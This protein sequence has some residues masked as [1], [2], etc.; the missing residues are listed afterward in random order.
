M[1]LDN[2]LLPNLVTLYQRGLLVP[3]IGSGMS[4]P[5][6]TSWNI[7]LATL[8]HQAGMD[9][10]ARK[11][12][13]A[14]ATLES[15]ALYR[16]A[17]TVVH[18]MH[19]LPH[20]EKARRYREG[21]H[22]HP[23]GSQPIP[24]QMKALT[25]GLYWP[26]VLTTNYDDLYWAACKERRNT[27]SLD[28]LSSYDKQLPL[29]LGR[30]LEDC[31]TVLRSLDRISPP[32][33]WAL[34]GFLGGQRTTP[35]EIVSD[36]AHLQEL[37]SQV[38][39]GHQQ[40]Q[41]AINGDSH[42]RRAFAEV[43]RRRSLLFLGSGILEDYLLNLFSEIIY[44]HGPSAFPHIAILPKHE[45]DSGR[46]D[47]RFL[48][49]R[50]GI[51]PLFWENYGDI[52]GLLS[53]LKDATLPQW[54]RAGLSTNTALLR[55]R[56]YVLPPKNLRVLLSFRSKLTPPRSGTCVAFSAGRGRIG[57]N[58]GRFGRKYLE[59]QGKTDH[60][61][62]WNLAS[63][64]PNKDLYQCEA[65]SVF[66]V[67]ARHPRGRGI[68]RD[69]ALIPD[70]VCGALQELEGKG[71]RKVYLGVIAAGA[72]S[73]KLWHPIH[74]FAQNLRGIWKFAACSTG[75][76]HEIEM[77][78]ID[79]RIWALIAADKL[80]I[81]EMLTASSFPFTVELHRADRHV[82][83]YNLL[84]RDGSTVGEVLAQCELE[85]SHWQVKLRPHP[86]DQP[87]APVPTDQIVTATM[88][89]IVFPS[90]IGHVIP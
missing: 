77:C 90:D 4:R 22:N 12:T 17:D 2:S 45:L 54:D 48:K 35:P 16:I 41:Q 89:L 33:Y 63:S 50:L 40:Y 14:T 86:T 83:T 18:K 80:P 46:F 51:T 55:S 21:I 30:S 74:P 23:V 25:D 49:T 32:L 87:D 26:L 10:D 42:F 34:Q 20:A 1:P 5:T 47:I 9:D 3:F 72:G 31:H 58:L 82:E 53:Q 71:Y 44:N 19:A 69:L 11:L 64:P 84:I 7:F 67:I 43:F 13:D 56:T 79:P 75:G 57:P 37:E 85:S 24:A 8:A 36:A 59:T 65:E 78:I 73:R 38:V 62:L 88:S 15:A 70:V 6:C 27:P 81:Q 60:P 66:A 76:L 61:T 52:P 29:I 39:V 28:A 68:Y